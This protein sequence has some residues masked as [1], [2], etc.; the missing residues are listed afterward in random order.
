MKKWKKNCEKPIWRVNKIKD[1]PV[2]E[3]IMTYVNDKHFVLFHWRG[4]NYKHNIEYN[5]SKL[6]HLT[7]GLKR[8]QKRK[9]TE[10]HT[11][12]L[13]EK[14]INIRISKKKY[15]LVKI[16]FLIFLATFLK[17]TSKKTLQTHS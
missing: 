6:K 12:V 8:V 5:R 13:F 2:K 3:I 1:F 11:D 10:K 14:S 4:V 16:V 9:E 15:M 17:K 7:E